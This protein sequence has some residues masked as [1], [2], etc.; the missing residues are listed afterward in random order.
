MR[1]IF[2]PPHFLDDAAASACRLLLPH[3]S[4]TPLTSIKRLNNNDFT[5]K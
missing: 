4:R 2:H 1:F 3:A 5:Q